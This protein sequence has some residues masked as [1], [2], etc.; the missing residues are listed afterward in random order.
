M[1]MMKDNLLEFLKI[2]GQLVS[3]MKF[4]YNALKKCSIYCH[5]SDSSVE[6]ESEG[7]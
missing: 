5:S 7:S 1:Q 2:S 3:Q 6:A 4:Y